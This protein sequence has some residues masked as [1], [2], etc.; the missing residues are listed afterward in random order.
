MHADTLTDMGNRLNQTK[1]LYVSADDGVQKEY[2]LDVNAWI[3][4]REIGDGMNIIDARWIDTKTGLYIDITGVAETKPFDKPGIFVA[5]NYDHS[6]ARDEIWPLRETIFEGE[7]A[8]IPYS[9][10]AMLEK[11]YNPK[12]LVTTEFEG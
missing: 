8:Q 3:F 7:R 1:H 6:Y 9:Y 11:E 12:A 4:E 5:K 2:F 10:V